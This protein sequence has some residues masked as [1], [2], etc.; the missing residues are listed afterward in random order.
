MAVTGLLRFKQSAIWVFFFLLFCMLLLLCFFPLLPTPPLFPSICFLA[1]LTPINSYLIQSQFQFPLLFY[2]T[3]LYSKVASLKRCQYV[4]VNSFLPFYASL[5][6]N[7]LYYKIS[8]KTFFRAVQCPARFR[9]FSV[10]QSFFFNIWAIF[11][12]CMYNKINL[13]SKTCWS[14]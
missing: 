13:D 10:R 14:K 9:C 5:Q 11:K 2:S 6:Q 4:M 7:L 8:S 12:C 1:F 3:I